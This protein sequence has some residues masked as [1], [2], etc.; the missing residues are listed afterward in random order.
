MV[1][2]EPGFLLIRRSLVR[3]QVEEPEKLEILK[4]MTR[5]FE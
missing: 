4:L 1:F 2:N 5:Q 3:A